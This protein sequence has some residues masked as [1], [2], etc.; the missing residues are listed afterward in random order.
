[1]M[2]P[3]VNSSIWL[4]PPYSLPENRFLPPFGERLVHVHAAVVANDRFRPAHAT[5]MDSPSRDPEPVA[6]G[7]RRGLGL[8]WVLVR[9]VRLAGL[10]AMPEGSKPVAILCLGHVESFCT[11]GH[12]R[13]RCQAPPRSKNC[14]SIAGVRQLR[15]RLRCFRR[16]RRFFLLIICAFF[17]PSRLFAANNARYSDFLHARAWYPEPDSFP[18]TPAQIQCTS[19]PEPRT[20]NASA[21]GINSGSVRASAYQPPCHTA[22]QW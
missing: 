9:S 17:A 11:T 5:E 8:G 12:A 19:I 7:T 18:L 14:S 22:S 10:L 13:A 1:M 4:K 20:A 16:C 2:P 15:V 21:A 6:R 3:M